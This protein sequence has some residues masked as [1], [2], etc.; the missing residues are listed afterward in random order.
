MLR[1]QIKVTYLDGRVVE[2]DGQPLDVLMDAPSLMVLGLL[3][4]H[5][6]KIKAEEKAAKRGNKA[7]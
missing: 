5:N 6:E 1:A 2:F 3:T 7:R 4:A